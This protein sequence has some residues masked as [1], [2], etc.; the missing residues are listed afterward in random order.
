MGP[1]HFNKSEVDVFMTEAKQVLPA[2]T[3]SSVANVSSDHKAAARVLAV[4]G[5]PAACKLLSLVLAPPAFRCP[6]ARSGGE[7]LVAL[8]REHF[9]AVIS[10]LHMPGIGGMGLLTEVRHLHPHL[11]FLVTTGVD[12]VDVGIRAMRCGADDYLVK[13]LQD[14]TVVASLESA[15]HKRQ[16]EQQIENYR[17]HLEEMVT[18]R[19]SQLQSALQQVERSYEDTLQALGAAMDL[20][21]HETGGH[22]QRVCRYSLEIA[23]AMG[24]SEKQ[25]ESLARAAYLH[26]IGKLGIPD[27]ILLK[28]GPL[29]ENERKFM[30]QHVQIR[31]DLVHDLA[32]LADAA[33]IILMHHER[34]DGGGYPRGLKGK[35][36]LPGAQIFAVA[37]T[38][39]ASTSDR[40]YRRP[41]SF[42]SAREA[43]RRGSGSQFD[44]EVVDAFLKIPED[45]LPTI[46]RNQRQI[47]ALSPELIVNSHR[48]RLELGLLP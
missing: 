14:G 13:P 24:G 16:L 39:D 37:D 12:D 8:Q 2:D 31:F 46:A 1:R 32:F 48:L 10:D 45:I 43:I 22:S 44:P 41:S 6:A 35:E 36:I 33:E 15:L 11:A 23:R 9:D 40:P 29:T 5:G 34:Y 42:E 7:V 20:R 19:T 47:A 38:L 26:D 25:L 18:E 27:G 21:D 3:E 30:Q 17:Q 28:P 4:D